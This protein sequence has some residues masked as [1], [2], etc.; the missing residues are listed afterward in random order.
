MPIVLQVGTYS[1]QALRAPFEIMMEPYWGENGPWNMQILTDPIEPGGI[2][3]PYEGDRHE[4]F[5]EF[6]QKQ[7][8]GIRIFFNAP[9]AFINVYPPEASGSPTS[10]W[11]IILEQRE[12]WK[13]A[14]LDK[15]FACSE[16]N[17]VV[18]SQDEILDLDLLEP[19]NRR[20]FPWKHWQLLTARV[21]D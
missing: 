20:T 6:M 1:R 19:L 7:L 4:L 15:L 18:T 14:I 8:H 9:Q 17:H 13:P 11:R 5:D 12:D 16:V 3:A 21:V 10:L 2:Y